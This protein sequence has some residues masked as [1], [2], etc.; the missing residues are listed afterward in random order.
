MI[1]ATHDGIFHADDVFAVA[2][3]KLIY[4]DIRIIRT[5]DENE[6]KKA[7]IC[8]DVGRK[9]DGIKNFDHHQ[10]DFTLK[11]NNIPY[12]SSGLIW[13]HFGNELVKSKE[14]FE[15]IDE[16][17]QTVDVA[18]NGI[19]II[20]VKEEFKD[21]YP[22]TLSRLIDSFNPISN[23][24]S[25]NYDKSFLKAVELAIVILKNEIAIANNLELS[26]KI[27]NKAIL[28]AKKE[29]KNYIVL[30]NLVSGW[31]KIID[32]DILFVVYRHPDKTWCVH[33]IPVKEENFENRKLFP[34][35]WGDLTNEKLAK[36]TGVKDA[37]FCHKGRFI[38]C[39]KTKQGT[40]KIAEMAV[41]S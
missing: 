14:A 6:L 34:E 23:E 5:R 33:S 27:I 12:A 26:R 8:L 39:C 36:I 28:K 31:K 10:N 20:N 18:D 37:F 40:I 1:I 7:D 15:H 17:L 24:E 30:N 16:I 25:I 29:N 19:D 21:I 4:K 2:I 38:V 11:R 9:Y 3:L 22:Y 32:K 41:K 35:E 13:K